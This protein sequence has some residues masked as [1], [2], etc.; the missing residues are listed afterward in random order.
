MYRRRLSLALGV[1]ALAF[2]LQGAV[3]WW[4]I[5]VATGHVQ[6]GRVVSDLL[7]A[8]LELS[9]TKQRLRS[10]TSQVL[11]QAG[12]DPQLRDRYQLDMLMT[13]ERLEGYAL[14]AAELDNDVHR[15]AID[16]AQRRETLD[17]LRRSLEELRV[18]LASARPMPR[19]ADPTVAWTELTRVFDAS[20]GRDLRS[21]LAQTIA[22]E[23]QAVNRERAAAD[24]SLSLLAAGALGATLVIAA[25]AAVLAMYFARALRQPLDELAAGAKA[26][27]RGELDQRIPDQRNDEFAILA[28]TVNAMAQELQQHRAREAQVR[29]DLEEQVQTRTAELQQALQ[30]LQSVD[31]SRRRLFADISHELRTPTTAIRGEAEIALRGRDKPLTEYQ[32]ALRRIVDTASQLGQIIDDLLTMARSD[33]EALSIQQRPVSIRTPLQEA[34]QQAQPLAASCQVALHVEDALP[35]HLCVLGDAARLRQLLMLLLDN[36]IRYSHRGGAVHIRT[37]CS[38]DGTRWQLE[39]HDQGIGLQAEELP[40]LFE[41][42]FRGTRARVHRADGSGLGLP[43][44]QTLTKSHGGQLQLQPHPEGGTV[45]RLSLPLRALDA[46]GLLPSSS[47]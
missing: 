13:L 32:D 28:R 7:K 45:A 29:H 18:A 43:L 10:W 6:R 11:L 23:Q 40:H 34:L 8:Y 42:H 35:E 36:A 22:R 24:R 5:D 25:A 21:L 1:L 16:L 2:M 27:Q 39:V 31:A 30:A 4:A 26:L 46:A 47:P 12:A 19:D 33:A 41:R 44:A 20:Q 3:A 17:I 37:R 14:R 38:D 9:A 15:A